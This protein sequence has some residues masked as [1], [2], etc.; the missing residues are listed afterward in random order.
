MIDSCF[1]IP[2]RSS[3]QMRDELGDMIWAERIVLLEGSL[4]EDCAE[5]KKRSSTRKKCE[6][7]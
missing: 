3:L 4:V 1:A 2:S 7:G 6:G 5:G